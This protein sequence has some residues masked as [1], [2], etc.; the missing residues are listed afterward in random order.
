MKVATFNANSLRIRL[1][2]ILKW[3]AEQ[4]PDILC[5][6]ETKVQDVDFPK[7][8]IDDAGTGYGYVFK[9]EKKYNGVAIFSNARISDVE[10]GFSE[11]PK[12]Q[13]RLICAKVKGVWIVNTY[14]PQGY[15]PESEKFQYKLKW[16]E[17]LGKYFES[18]F[19]PNDPVIWAGDLNVAMDE[20]DVHD[21]KR[22]LGHVCYCP[23][24]QQALNEVVKWGFTD[25]FRQH[26]Q[27]GG[28][29]TFWDYRQ[30]SG[31]KN[32]CGWRLDYIM[33]TSK[34][35]KKC[36]SCWIDKGPRLL[37][38]PSDHTFLIAEFDI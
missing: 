16:F 35:A 26:C 28:H 14:V 27:E 8:A 30:R 4:K 18:N 34:L 1:P 38:K 20:R 17:R 6:Q 9:G 36:S 24:A 19:S 32:N 7:D 29:Y 21:P 22:L 25:V 13:A 33:A 15:S 12:D 2:V 3:L 10:V 31:F 37:E 5:I 11:E 23:E